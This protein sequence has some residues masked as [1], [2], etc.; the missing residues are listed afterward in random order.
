MNEFQNQ[1]SE[2]IEPTPATY[3]AEPAYTAE[4]TNTTEPAFLQPAPAKKKGNGLK[5]LVIALIVVLLITNGGCIYLL[6]SGNNNSLESIMTKEEIIRGKNQYLAFDTEGLIPVSIDEEYGYMNSDGEIVI[7]PEFDYASQF[8][9][10]IAFVAK[11]KKNGEPK[12]A[13][14]DTNGDFVVEYGDYDSFYGFSYYEDSD[15]YYFSD[16]FSN[17]LIVAERDDRYGYI[18]K[19]GEEVTD[20]IFLELSAMYNDGYAYAITEDKEHVIIDS[21]G[22][23]VFVIDD[24]IDYILG[25]SI[26]KLCAKGDCVNEVEDDEKY[27]SEHD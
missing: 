16:G 22:E 5:I 13:I 10:G 19:N 4:P 24:D 11:T 26:D 20:F 21:D 15:N 7:E 2:I 9:D 23:I 17:G 27:C 12:Y 1:T 18:N 14:I 3:A 6:L 25:H 8:I